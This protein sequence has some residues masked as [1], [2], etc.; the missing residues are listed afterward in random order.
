MH[1]TCSPSTCEGFLMQVFSLGSAQVPQGWRSQQVSQLASEGQSPDPVAE[2]PG[3]SSIGH[4]TRET[5]KITAQF[6][7]LILHFPGMGTK[8]TQTH[9]I[10]AL[11]NI[12]HR[13]TC[14]HWLYMC[15]LR[16]GI[17]VDLSLP[18]LGFVEFHKRKENFVKVGIFY[19]FSANTAERGC[20]TQSRPG[21]W[22]TRCLNAAYLPLNSEL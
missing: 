17:N 20:W 14:T 7:V 21:A 6:P 12:W 3:A 13:E 2:R 22:D 9:P 19:S 11:T 5:T 16:S 10:T 15:Y 4:S 8:H 1:F 18:Y